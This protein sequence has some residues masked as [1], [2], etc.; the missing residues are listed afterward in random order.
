MAFRKARILILWKTY[1]SPS[2]AHTETSC[3]AGVEEDGKPIRLYPAPFRLIEEGSRFK[4]WQWIKAQVEKSN[5]DH[6]PESHRIGVETP[7]RCDVD[8]WRSDKTSSVLNW[9]SAARGLL[10]IFVPLGGRWNL[11]IVNSRAAA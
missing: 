4:K 9:S 11:T 5:K 10:V 7:E 1:P 8:A 6:R 2:T 3:I